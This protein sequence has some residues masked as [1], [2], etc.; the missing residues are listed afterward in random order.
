MPNN[1]TTL[2]AISFNAE[3]SEVQH[4]MT[5]YVKRGNEDS[6]TGIKA[7]DENKIND[8]MPIVVLVNNDG[9]PIEYKGFTLVALKLTHLDKPRSVELL[10]RE[11]WGTIAPDGDDFQVHL[12]TVK[13]SAWRK[14]FAGELEAKSFGPFDYPEDKKKAMDAAEKNRKALNAAAK[15]TNMD[16]ST[17]KMLAGLDDEKRAKLLALLAE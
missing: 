17:L 15:A 12:R 8:H 6:R 16:T 7:A 11:S 9:E 5:W 3:L 14:T 2:E 4:A 10:P 1:K 13:G